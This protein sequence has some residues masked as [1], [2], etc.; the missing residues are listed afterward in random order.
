MKAICVDDAALILE[1]TISQLKQINSIDNVEG[2]THPSD[3]LE[4]VKQN[5][6]DIALLDIDM[7]D[8]NGIA[9][10]ITPIQ[11]AFLLRAPYAV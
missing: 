11:P 1:H 9:L 8:M 10:A 3:A 4:Y 5:P 6:V 2:F 7:P